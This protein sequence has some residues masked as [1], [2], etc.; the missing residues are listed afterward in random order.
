MDLCNEVME[1]IQFRNENPIPGVMTILQ[2]LGSPQEMK[3]RN[4]FV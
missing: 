1:Y 3:I 4:N 2:G